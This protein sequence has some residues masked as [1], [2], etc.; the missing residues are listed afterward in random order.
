[1]PSEETKVLE[2]HGLGHA[3]WAVLFT[4]SYHF[5]LPLEQLIEMAADE[6]G[7]TAGTEAVAAAVETALDRGWLSSWTSGTGTAGGEPAGRGRR[8]A[9]DGVVL[10]EQGLRVKDAVASDLMATLYAGAA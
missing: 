7:G 6:A 3:E 9:Q 5:P 4:A 1:M 2:A 8:A 10:T